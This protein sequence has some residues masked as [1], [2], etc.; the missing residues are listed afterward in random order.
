MKKILHAAFAA[1]V[2]AIGL[3]ACDATPPP[4]AAVSRP[5][6]S[7]AI[8]V[9]PPVEPEG[10]ATRESIADVL[11]DEDVY[12]RARRLGALLPTLG[13]EAAAAVKEVLGEK[14]LDFGAIEIELLVR[15]WATHQPEDASRWA[16]YES[17]GAF[18]VPAI[19][20]SFTLWAEADPQAALKAAK[21]WLVYS[22][23]VDTALQVAL[24]RGWFANNPP[25][26]EQY[27]Y[28]LG[29]SFQR[30]RAL[31]AFIRLVIQK[32]GADA[33]MRWAEAIP[34]DDA[35]SSYKKVAYARTTSAL[36]L[37]D[38]EAA[39]RWCEAHC[40]ARYGWGMRSIIARVW[41][42]SDGPAA[43]AWL[44]TAPEGYES[45]LAVRYTFADWGRRD[46]EAA[47]AWMAARTTG[48]PDPRLRPIFP[49]YARL[50]LQDSR[51]LEAI[52]WAQRIE[53]EK[54]REDLLVRL[55]R[56]WRGADAA[57]AEAW[58]RQSSLSEE[59]RQK[60]RI[61]MGRPARPSG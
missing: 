8:A 2:G 50:L 29:K 48:E 36:A 55:L 32:R 61:P 44:S 6:E 40:D 30:Q 38:R 21:E 41:A 59:K 60:A 24:V 22:D 56:E 51:P 26:L 34:D 1:A 58:L 17:P 18:R 3:A 10:M 13:P 49:V 31:T 37:F 11:R 43:L 9:S 52:E 45:D 16:F 12:S 25:E 57:A 19:L 33:V 27:I 20:C 35:V 54:D 39:M 14:T 53:D 15:F 47:M 5:A 42:R 7:E 28:D 4:E 46:P 23:E